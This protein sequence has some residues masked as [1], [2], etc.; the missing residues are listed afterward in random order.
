MLQSKIFSKTLR[1]DPKD[2]VSTNAKL[3]ERGGFIYK[4]MAGVYDFL[5]LGWRVLNKINNIIREEMNA[6]GGQEIFLTAMQ[7]RERWEKTGRWKLLGEEVMYQFKDRFGHEVGLASTHEEAVTEIATRFIQSYKDLPLAVY[8]IQTKYRSESRAKS[9]LIR[10]REF[11]MK[12]LYSFHATTEDLDR[13]YKLV[14]ESYLKIFKR[15]GLKTFVTEASGG[16]FSKDFSHEYQVLSDAGED[17]II[18]CSQC[19]F[20]QNKEISSL[21]EGGDCSKCGNKLKVGKSIEVGNIFKLGTKFSDAFGLYYTDKE[22]GKKPVI[23]ASYG[24][25]PGRLMG[26]IVEIHSDEDGI[27]WPEEVSPFKIHLI[28]LGDKAKNEAENLYKDL[29]AENIEVLYDN[30]GDKTPGEKFSDAD[31]L[32]I[33]WRVVVSEKTMEKKGVELKKR[34]EKQAKIITIQELLKI[35]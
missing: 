20:A 6:V 19:G 34:D 13:Y 10:G 29:L 7:P 25:G 28:A 5:P 22:G 26:T 1:E 2:E 35:K 30:R 14:D 31:L 8:Q 11:L 21:D 4:T 32:G 12:D 23:M 27:L 3:L 33:P 9:G 15:C 24:I 16:V 18:F 17:K